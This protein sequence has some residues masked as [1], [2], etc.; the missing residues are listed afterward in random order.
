M[1][2]VAARRAGTHDLRAPRR[3]ATVG[4]WVVDRPF[5]QGVVVFGESQL[6]TAIRRVSLHTAFHSV[7]MLFRPLSMGEMRV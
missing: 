2:V 3:A 7:A 5:L 4:T 1:V 6:C